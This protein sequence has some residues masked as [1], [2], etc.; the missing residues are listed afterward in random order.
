MNFWSRGAIGGIQLQ[1]RQGLVDHRD[2]KRKL[3]PTQS[4]LWPLYTA[5]LEGLGKVPPQ[6]ATEQSGRQVTR[7]DVCVALG[8][9]YPVLG[10]SLLIHGMGLKRQ[11]LSSSLSYHHAS[12]QLSPQALTRSGGI[13]STIPSPNPLLPAGGE[14]LLSWRY[15]VWVLSPPL[16]DSQCPAESPLVFKIESPCNCVPEDVLKNRES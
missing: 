8:N 4:C 7:L 13:G 10:L 12:H 6:E 14:G 2:K 15:V 11:S 1:G 16:G 9:L 3:I 5:S